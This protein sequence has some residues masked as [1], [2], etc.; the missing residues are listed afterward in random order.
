[1]QDHKT[2]LKHRVHLFVVSDPKPSSVKYWLNF[3]NFLS[4]QIE[5]FFYF[6]P[7][8][9]HA[10]RFNISRNK[11]PTAIKFDEDTEKNITSGSK[12]LNGSSRSQILNFWTWKWNKSGRIFKIIESRVVLRVLKV[13]VEA[14]QWQCGVSDPEP[15]PLNILWS[16][17]G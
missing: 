11:I 1:M 13:L 2:F 12:W 6:H 14:Q 16:W 10:K 5:E 9:K 15:Q 4:S 7:P 3:E 8:K 17:I